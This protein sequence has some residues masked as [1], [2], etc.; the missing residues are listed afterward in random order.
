MCSKFVVDV[1]KY[2]AKVFQISGFRFD[3]MGLLDIE[4]L[5]KAYEEL[6]TIDD[7]IMVYGEGWNM[8]STIPDNQK[9]HMYNH[10][11]IPQYAFFN[12]RFRDI[13]RGNQFKQDLGYAFGGNKSI[14]EIYHL[15]LGSCLDYF[16]FQSPTQSST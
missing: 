13:V 1:L 9:P 11:K 2:Y 12:D 14:Y 16:K 4:T 15:N 5:N 3:L 7:G 8:Q 6:K 10:N